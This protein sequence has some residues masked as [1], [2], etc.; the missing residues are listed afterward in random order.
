MTTGSIIDAISDPP[1]LV[2]V[3]GP[4]GSYDANPG[5]E[6]DVSERDVIIALG[7][8]AELLSLRTFVEG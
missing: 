7:S 6:V 4:G 2:A 1:L 8:A 3:R 5:P